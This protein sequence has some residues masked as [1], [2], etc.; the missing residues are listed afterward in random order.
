MVALKTSKYGWHPQ[1]DDLDWFFLGA[2]KVA[3]SKGRGRDTGGL[4]IRIDKQLAQ[5]LELS[6]PGD[7]GRKYSDSKEAR[8]YFF[9]AVVG[10]WY[11]LFFKN[12]LPPRA[13]AN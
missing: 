13:I 4:V 12:K 2:R 1:W 8:E 11:V 10:V 6:P 5:L 3:K 7:D 9:C